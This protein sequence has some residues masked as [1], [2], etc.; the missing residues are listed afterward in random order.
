MYIER[1]QPKLCVLP[2][3]Y[4]PVTELDLNSSLK[5]G[6]REG[7]EEKEVDKKEVKETSRTE[8][9]KNL[10]TCSDKE[11]KEKSLRLP[12]WCNVW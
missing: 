9:K 8:E 4:P 2:G 1:S 3:L 10:T 7:A 6:G 12:P 11:K 5:E